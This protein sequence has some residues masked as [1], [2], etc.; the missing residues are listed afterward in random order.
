MIHRPREAGLDAPASLRTER[1]IVH[2]PLF[3]PPLHL[4][5]P[6]IDGQR[7]NYYDWIAAG[8]YRSSDGSIH[9]GN[10]LID[11]LRFGFDDKLFYLRAEG[12]LDPVRQAKEDVSLMLEFHNPRSLKFVFQGGRLQIVPWNG[13]SQEQGSP[14]GAETSRSLL[15][16]KTSARVGRAASRG[17]VAIGSVAEAGIPLEELG[18]R[19]GDFLDFAISL[20]VGTE[21]IDRLPQSGFISVSVPPPDFGGENWSV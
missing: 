19:P 15:G 4:F 2:S 12:N 14:A 11:R 13:S 7:G 6:K 18:T 16:S 5:T 8:F 10:R 21:A 9:R 17:L 3:Q 1:R 20:R